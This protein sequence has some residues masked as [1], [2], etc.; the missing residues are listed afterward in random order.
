LEKKVGAR[1]KNK[2]QRKEEKRRGGVGSGREVKRE[3]R[4]RKEEKGGEGNKGN[5][6]QDIGRGPMGREGAWRMLS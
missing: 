1:S 2:S 3:E 4:K 6:R 5:G